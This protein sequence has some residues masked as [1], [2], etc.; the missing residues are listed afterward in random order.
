[1]GKLVHKTALAPKASHLHVSRVAYNSWGTL[2]ISKDLLSYGMQ[3]AHCCTPEAVVSVPL[4]AMLH[5]I[6][7]LT[8]FPRTGSATKPA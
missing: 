8:G 7:P 4:V 2:V 6:A 1:M 3:T 5:T